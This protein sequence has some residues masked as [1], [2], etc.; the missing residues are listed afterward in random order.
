MVTKI[1]SL[2]IV[3]QFLPNILT[4]KPCT[5]PLPLQF[6]THQQTQ[7][8]VTW[9]ADKH[10]TNIHTLGADVGGVTEIARPW[11]C[12]WSEC[13][14][15][16]CSEE[17]KE[18]TREETRLRLRSESSASG[19]FL[20]LISNLQYTLLKGVLDALGNSSILQ[21][22]S[23]NNV[24]GISAKIEITLLSGSYES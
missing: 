16:E 2:V 6:L 22:P 21:M 11:L 18:G 10:H 17:G 19:W 7:H 12:D 23:E 20:F 8:M 13:M 3:T 14:R 9:P 15:K 1:F 5:I 24:L 4:A